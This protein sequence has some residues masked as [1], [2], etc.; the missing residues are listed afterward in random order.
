MAK[1]ECSPCGGRGEM[2]DDCYECGGS[3]KVD[4]DC[5]ECDGTGEVQEEEKIV[6]E[7]V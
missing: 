3:G 4:I 6:S 2:E 5:E 1:K 7:A